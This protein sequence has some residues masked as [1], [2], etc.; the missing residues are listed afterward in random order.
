MNKKELYVFHILPFLHQ[1]FKRNENQDF[2]S[3]SLTLSI[4]GI[5]A[6]LTL[7]EYSNYYSKVQLLLDLAAFLLFHPVIGWAA[8]TIDLRGC[9]KAPF[10]C[11]LQLNKKM[12][13]KGRILCIG[14]LLPVKEDA[15]FVC[16]HLR[17]PE[18]ST[19]C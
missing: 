19:L 2:D 11:M 17:F 18:S 5:V 10:L 16:D 14:G 1:T 15:F 7:C 6:F 8:R 13:F 9:R 4:F 12:E 3:Q